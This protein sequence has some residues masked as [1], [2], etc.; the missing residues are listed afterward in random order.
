MVMVMVMAGGVRSEGTDNL[1]SRYGEVRALGV[2][3]VYLPV[4]H[5]M[6]GMDVGW[7][8]NT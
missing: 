6:D 8:M 2:L 3:V 1:D 7:R 4:V 5:R